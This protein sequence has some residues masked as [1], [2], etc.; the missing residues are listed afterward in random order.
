MR[1]EL[2]SYLVCPECKDSLEINIIKQENGEIIEGKLSCGECNLGFPVRNGIPRMALKEDYF[3]KERTKKNFAFSWRKFA[4]IYQD[5]RDFLNWI[6]PKNKY[7]FKD[8]IVLDAGCGT[9]KHALFASRFGAKEVIAFDLSNSVEVAF[10]LTLPAK[11]VHIIQA[12]IYHLP[13]KSN[14]D[15][16]YSI[17]VLQHLPNPKKGFENLTQLLKGKG[18]IS[19]WVYGYEGTGL[20]RKIIDPIRKNI[21]SKMPLPLVFLLSFFLTIVFY[22]ISKGIYRPLS[23]F[24]ITRKILKFLPMN[25]YVL[26]ISQFNFSHIFN[27]IFDQLIAPIT[28]YFYKEEIEQWFRKTDLKNIIISDR[29]NMSW[30]ASGQK[31][32]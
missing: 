30:R 21:T 24:K 2:L 12:D 3:L 16:I 1:P 27:S 6:Y 14:F 23:K 4:N 10:D 20:V 7:F 29:N 18:W 25:S 9:G 15:Y 28:N 5:P 22:L 13:F 8:K 32:S 19:I 26:Y 31:L 11:N 17:G